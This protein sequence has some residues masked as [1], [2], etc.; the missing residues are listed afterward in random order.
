MHSHFTVN[1]FDNKYRAVGRVSPG[2][3]PLK[4]AHARMPVHSENT[5]LAASLM[6]LTASGTYSKSQAFVF[7]LPALGALGRAASGGGLCERK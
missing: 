2:F 7:H 6:L 5:N 1:L 4:G 3:N